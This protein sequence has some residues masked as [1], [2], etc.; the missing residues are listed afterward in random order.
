MRVGKVGPPSNSGTPVRT[1]RI[2]ADESSD[3]AVRCSPQLVRSNRG[4]TSGNE[5][6]PG[7][8]SPAAGASRC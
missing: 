3:A 4:P 5:P 2:A 8:R 6:S 7:K 1:A